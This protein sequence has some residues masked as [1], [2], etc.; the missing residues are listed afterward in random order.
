MLVATDKLLH[1]DGQIALFNDSAFGIANDPGELLEAGR[2]L[3]GTTDERESGDGPWALRDAGYFGFRDGGAYVICDAGP[4]GPDYMPG[5]AHGDIFSF[6][7]SFDG[8]RMVVD[9]GVYSYEAGEMR[10]YCRSTRAHNTVEIDEQDQCEFWEVF[11]VGRRGRPTYVDWE[12]GP[13]GFRLAS[14][15]DGYSRLPGSPSHQRSF[16]Y[17]R[18]GRLDIEDTIVSSRPVRVASRVH[19]HPE[20]VIEQLTDDSAVIVSGDRRVLL[21]WS[22]AVDELVH[23]DSW[24]CPEF[25]VREKNA[26][27]ACLSYGSRINTTLRSERL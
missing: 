12:P 17:D 24:Y 13:D 7:L 19:L 3:L 26:C 8:R 1:P 27:L 18:S 16:T 5:H 15:H 23:E 22:G 14:R 11:R 10:R 6:E 4:V 9:G 20:C 25:G 21:S 2:S